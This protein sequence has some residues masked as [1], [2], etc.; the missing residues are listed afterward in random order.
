MGKAMKIED[1]A[2]QAIK[3]AVD[4]E[5]IS[6]HRGYTITQE[7]KELPEEVREQAAAE[8]IAHEIENTKSASARTIQKAALPSCFALPLKRGFR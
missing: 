6:I 8:A 7:L 3:T 2:P 4:N 5:D 1:A